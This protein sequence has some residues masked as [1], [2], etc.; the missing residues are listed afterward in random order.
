MSRGEVGR[1]RDVCLRERMVGGEE[2][3]RAGIGRHELG[4]VGQITMK[5]FQ[6]H[7]DHHFRGQ[8]EESKGLEMC[9]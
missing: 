6:L 5:R 9:C 4:V 8:P 2:T 1:K 7:R 3:Q